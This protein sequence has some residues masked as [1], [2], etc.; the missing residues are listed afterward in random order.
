MKTLI[1]KLILLLLLNIGI[2]LF[3]FLLDALYYGCV[4]ILGDIVG[5]IY[6]N[7]PKV[8]G[9]LIIV[10]YI[11]FSLLIYNVK[12]IQNK[13]CKIIYILLDILFLL[14][15]IYIFSGGILL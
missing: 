14:N 11:A 2:V 7:C 3:V 15:L 9:V 10:V 4:D 1:I 5:F 8:L 12:P 13:T 6:N